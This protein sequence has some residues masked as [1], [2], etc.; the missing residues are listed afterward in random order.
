MVRSNARGA[1]LLSSRRGDVPVLGPCE[2]G[3][4]GQ[5]VHEDW[6]CYMLRL[7]LAGGP[8]DNGLIEAGGGTSR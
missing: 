4:E 6:L 3:E 5:E 2:T 8:P 7:S 1:G